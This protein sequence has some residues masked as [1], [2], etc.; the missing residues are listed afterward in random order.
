MTKLEVEGTSS[1]RR[2]INLLCVPLPTCSYNRTD[3][4]PS[5]AQVAVPTMGHMHLCVVVTMTWDAQ[6][7]DAAPKLLRLRHI[8]PLS[9][10]CR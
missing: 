3:P 8:K 9:P 1:D 10:S 2:D 7:K 5:T 4:Q 6:T